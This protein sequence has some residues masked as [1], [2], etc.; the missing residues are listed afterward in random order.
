M[1]W[2]RRRKRRGPTPEARL[3]DDCRRA[4]GFLESVLADAARLGV[5][6]DEGV[7]ACVVVLRAWADRVD[8]S[9]LDR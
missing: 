2:R 4:L 1:S 9:N 3:Q 7:L 6:V 5:P 8:R